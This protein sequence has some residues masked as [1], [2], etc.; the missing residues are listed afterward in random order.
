MVIF[1]LHMIPFKTE[2][3]YTVEKIIKLSERIASDAGRAAATLHAILPR[4]DDRDFKIVW[5]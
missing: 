1:W 3:L 5:N 2:I 4:D